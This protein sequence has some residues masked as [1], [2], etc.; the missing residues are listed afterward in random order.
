MEDCFIIEWT[1]TPN[2]Y[3]EESFSISQQECEVEI[4]QGKV[5]AK[6]ETVS[7]HEAC[8]I[9][10]KLHD[11][12]LSRFL[13]A[14]VVKHF[15]FSLSKS[16]ICRQY[17]DGHKDLF[18]S[19][20][21]V[22]GVSVSVSQPD[23]IITDQNGNVTSDTRRERI[24]SIQRLGDLADKF[25]GTDLTA[26]A[27]L[28]SYQA[29]VNDPGNELIHLYEIRDA[30]NERF[31]KEKAARKA[32]GITHLDWKRL[33]ELANS[34]PLRQGRHRGENVGNLRDATESELD[35]AR[36]IARAFI[37]KYLNYLDQQGPSK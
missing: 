4:G 5:Q 15:S 23:I 27:V 36:K 8:A 2:D 16:H 19:V 10:D 30:L 25:R 37:Q 20:S 3:F 9:S 13:A 14:Q 21:G 31:K 11:S 1:Y 17:A 6:V 24:N 35:E 22:I 29:A 18:V 34:E 12:L 33:G 32:L 28:R 26:D 7:Y